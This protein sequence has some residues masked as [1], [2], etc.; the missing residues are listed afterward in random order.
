MALSIAAK[1]AVYIRSI[2]NE[3]GFADTKPTLVNSDN[4][5]AQFLVKILYIMQEVST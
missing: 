4:Q 2:L 3:L 1:E 5:G